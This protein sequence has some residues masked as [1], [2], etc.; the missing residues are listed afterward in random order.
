MPFELDSLPCVVDS[1]TFALDSMSSVVDSM[2]FA[3]DSMSSVVDSLSG[4]L[5]LQG[6]GGC[7][8][9]RAFTSWLLT[10]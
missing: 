8:R 3:L 10:T 2:T 6:S 5:L 4:C 1:M 9:G 7:S